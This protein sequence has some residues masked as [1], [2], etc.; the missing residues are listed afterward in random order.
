MNKVVCILLISLLVSE[1]ACKMA[2]TSKEV[3]KEIHFP[4]SER[5]S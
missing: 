5:I 1:M 2:L 3:R 4:K